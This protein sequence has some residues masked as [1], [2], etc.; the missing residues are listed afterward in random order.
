M[1]S[2]NA[3]GVSTTMVPCLLFD[4]VCS[5]GSAEQQELVMSPLDRA[6]Q[7]LEAD[8]I[9]ASLMVSGVDCTTLM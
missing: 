2:V 7:A 9:D 1:P 4:C 6:R 3:V 8:P 5:N